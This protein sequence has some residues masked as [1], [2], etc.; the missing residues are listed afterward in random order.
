MRLRAAPDGAWRCG[1]WGLSPRVRMCSSS[2]GGACCARGGGS[3]GCGCGSAA[4]RR[5]CAGGVWRCGV[6]GPVVWSRG[7]GSRWERRGC[8]ARRLWSCCTCTPVAVLWCCGSACVAA[9]RAVASTIGRSGGVRAGSRYPRLRTARTRSWCVRTTGTARP[10]SGSRQRSRR[11]GP[12]APPRPRARP[13]APRH[14]PPARWV[15]SS[16]SCSRT[17]L[18]ADHRSPVRAAPEPSRLGSADRRQLLRRATA[19][20]LPNYIADQQAGRPRASPTTRTIRASARRAESPSRSFGSGM[21]VAR[22]GDALQ[23]RT[24]RTPATTRTAQPCRLLT[25][26]FARG[27]R[28]RN[29]PLGTTANVSARFGFTFVTPNLCH[30]IH[31]FLFSTSNGTTDSGAD[32]VRCRTSCRNVL[33]V[34]A[35]PAGRTASSSP[36]TR[37]TTPA[38]STSR[39][40]SWPDRARGRAPDAN[41][42]SLLAFLRTTEDT[43]GLPLLG[44]AAHASSMRASFRL[45]PAHIAGSE[46][47]ALH[48]RFAGAARPAGYAVPGARMPR[49]S[50]SRPRRVGVWRCG[51]SARGDGPHMF[52][53]DGRRMLR[54]RRRVVRFRRIAAAIVAGECARRRLVVRRAGL[55][56]SWRG[57]FRSRASRAPARPDAGLV[58]RARGRAAR[59]CSLSVSDRGGDCR[60]DGG[61]RGGVPRGSL[62]RVGRRFRDR[63]WCEQPVGARRDDDPPR[64]QIF[65]APTAP[66]PADRAA[67]RRA[68]VRRRLQ[69]ARGEHHGVEPL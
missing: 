17:A 10:P 51:W 66:A 24:S 4:R 61:L 15:T 64:P 7:P 42:R 22:R 55:A 2:M 27:A 8:A 50:G 30:D 19:P 68:R 31:S 11:P 23:L 69:R 5:L 3:C 57:A 37:T 9:R 56:V 36:R 39:R 16:G 65:G 49:G 14:T 47:R 25:R 20:G 40:S 53:L 34:S 52:A 44:N 21:A 43:L 62:R 32:Q 60:V 35:V 13:A 67:R 38:R 58:R 45:G 59:S 29:V 54:S 33:G 12:P 18:R 48:R 46:R 28:G 41:A 26:T 1:S 63:S 6:C